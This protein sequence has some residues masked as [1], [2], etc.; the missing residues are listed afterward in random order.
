MS[1]ATVESA[2]AD[3]LGRDG[4]LP[5]QLHTSPAPTQNPVFFVLICCGNS[6]TSVRNQQ[7]LPDRTPS[8]GRL[9]DQATADRS[10][11]T[12][13]GL[14]R[15]RAGWLRFAKARPHM[16][17]FRGKPCGRLLACKYETKPIQSWMPIY[18]RFSAWSVKSV[19]A[20]APPRSS[21]RP[22]TVCG[23]TA[24]RPRLGAAAVSFSA[25]SLCS[26]IA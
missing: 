7:H 8:A 20:R 26:S 12:D 18:R 16:P 17:W 22:I 10:N 14:L 6:A 15:A 13:T 4:R 3:R 23:R 24:V 5:H 2:C 9:S 1:E 21:R 25:Q 11:A 19:C